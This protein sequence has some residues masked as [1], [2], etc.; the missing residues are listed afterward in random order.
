MEK[1]RF[2]AVIKHLYLNGLILKEIKA[3]LNEVHGKSAPA[4][5]T[6]YNWANE[7]KRSRTSTKY[8]HRSRRPVEVTTLELIDKIYDIAR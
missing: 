8:E 1:S 4:F 7:F 3:K 5:A 6:V 2:Q